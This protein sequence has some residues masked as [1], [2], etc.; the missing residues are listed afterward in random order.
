MQDQRAAMDDDD[1]VVCA[2]C[3]RLAEQ[4]PDLV[5]CE[6]YSWHVAQDMPAPELH[7]GLELDR[8]AMV[9]GALHLTWCPTAG[10][11]CAYSARD[12]RVALD[13]ILA[14]QP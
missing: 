7:T 4:A 3:G 8:L 10:K 13:A 14:V 6:D 11:G 9:A 12:L 5:E 2:S 1:P